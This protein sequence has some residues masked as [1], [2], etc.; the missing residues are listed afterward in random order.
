MAALAFGLIGAWAAPAVGLAASTGWAIGSY[1][2]GAIFRPTVRIDGPR[3]QDTKVQTST[4]GTAIPIVY[5]AMRIAG[6]VIDM[7]EIREHSTTKKQRGK[8]GGTKYT[9]Y[10]YEADV[11]VGLCEGEIAGVAKIWANG[12]L[13]YSIA[14]DAT[15]ETVIASNKMAEGF[16]VYTGSETQM[17]DATLEAL[18][19]AGNVPA[20]RGIAY[21]VFSTLWLE[22]YG[23]RLPNFEFEVVKVGTAS[24]TVERQ[25][26][27]IVSGATVASLRFSG[28][29]YAGDDDAFEC[30]LLTGDIDENGYPI[31]G[32]RRFSG[33]YAA[34]E[35]RFTLT[36]KNIGVM[37]GTSDQPCFVARC[38]D[39]TKVYITWLKD[40]GGS[41]HLLVTFPVAVESIY[42]I[43]NGV[44]YVM[45]LD[46]KYLL[47]K[48]IV[49]GDSRQTA[50]AFSP[51]LTGLYNYY[52]EVA[53]GIVYLAHPLTK[54]IRRW[55]AAT[56][57]A[58][59]DISLTGIAQNVESIG[60]DGTTLFVCHRLNVE[61]NQNRTFSILNADGSL[62]PY[63]QVVAQNDGVRRIS[64]SANENIHSRRFI[65]NNGQIYRLDISPKETVGATTYPQAITI[66]RVMSPLGA[67]TVPLGGIVQDLCARV[68]LTAIDKTALDSTQVAGY[69]M[70]RQA[71]VRGAI[72]PLQSAYFFDAVESG[73]VLKFV[74]RGGA[75]VAS[76]PLDDLCAGIDQADSGDPLA[77]VRA[78]EVDLPQQVTISYSNLDAAYQTSAEI[79]QRIVT[80]SV[81][82]VGAELPIAMTATQ[83]ARIADAWMYQAY[84]GRTS[85]KF[86][87]SRQYAALEPCDVVTVTDGVQTFTARI[88]SKMDE[89]GV[90]A[91]EAENE[92][93]I[94]YNSNAQGAG[95]VPPVTQ[96]SL[97][98]DSVAELID[99]AIMRDQ[100]DDAGF[101]AAL[102]PR[103]PN[104]RW[105]GAVLLTGSLSDPTNELGG[106]TRM[107]V[108]GTILNALPATNLSGAVDAV[109]APN[110]FDES[111][112]IDVQLNRG[113]LESKSVAEIFNLENAAVIGN[114]IIQFRDAVLTGDRQYRLTGIL[115]GRRGTEDLAAVSKPAGTRFVLMS[116]EDGILRPDL[117]TLGI[118]VQGGYRAVTIGGIVQQADIQLFTNSARG[119]KP[120]APRRAYGWKTSTGVSYRW[121]RRSR[122]D[123]GWRNG[124]DV[125]IGE[126]TEAY[127]I[128]M[129]AAGGKLI[130]TFSSATQTLT[131][132][133]AQITA[134]FNAYDLANGGTI[135]RSW[136]ELSV[137]QV[138]ATVGAGLESPA[139]RITL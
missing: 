96:I 2:G 78:Q 133:T 59:P 62:T 132:T 116:G 131:L 111:I 57:T 88:T 125:P 5:G 126:A 74:K 40:G 123:G 91:F 53:N 64:F 118:G 70:G 105:G 137:A 31:C 38:E 124:V 79:A 61:P 101:Y 19:G 7:S 42:R 92:N 16:T 51:A 117:G 94:Q 46:G 84:A 20:Y 104:G 122:I 71:A 50:T 18:H 11:A 89:G 13:I 25:A 3:L 83:A 138:S 55:N 12:E 43:S 15:V 110:F 66:G 26:Q 128:Y 27:S 99:T 36:Q 54:H 72:E 1:L 39:P 80:P 100:D 37:F 33:V 73:G 129:R 58:L 44:I 106:V 14:P 32:V 47:S 68:G 6:N 56:L 113:E 67:Q 52:L 48:P 28:A 86:K 119:L 87:L 127:T 77:V 10:T 29:S 81:N 75:P 34:D 109:Q 102:A 135:S 22:K 120:Y 23:N 112:F 103:S 139:I 63:A 136:I 134:A 4:Y 115:R 95:N 60:S 97:I 98:A 121:T 35:E 85:M 65:V 9:T 82:K 49:G 41:G 45:S 17:P 93:G 21:V 130:T 24:S 107:G 114:E 30:Y 90:Y 69:V 8:G 76:I 108:I